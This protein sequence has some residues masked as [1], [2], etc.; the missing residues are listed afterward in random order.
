MLKVA[1]DVSFSIAFE[2]ECSINLTT[3]YFTTS[4]ARNSIE[5]RNFLYISKSI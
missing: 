5:M 4:Y 2:F 3:I 1:W